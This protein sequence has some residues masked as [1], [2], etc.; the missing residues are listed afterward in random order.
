MYY[1]LLRQ[2]IDKK[3]IGVNDG[4]AQAEIIESK[5]H[6]KKEL[7]RYTDEYILGVYTTLEK[8][9]RGEFVAPPAFGYIKVRNKAIITD[10]LS[11]SEGYPGGRFLISN[12][13][14]DIL[15][16]FNVN[17][18]IYENIPLYHLDNLS[19]GIRICI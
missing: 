7:R 18:R 8:L 6:N 16:E 11:F 13:V 17:C 4:G 15:D 9:E 12:K 14:K 3:I 10:F 19:K 2:P 1:Y 5:W